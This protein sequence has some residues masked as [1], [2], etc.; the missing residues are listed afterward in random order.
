[1]GGLQKPLP[2]V[3]TAPVVPMALAPTATPI[4]NPEPFSTPASLSSNANGS[5]KTK[6]LKGT[7]QRYSDG[8]VVV[9]ATEALSAKR[10]DGLDG[11]LLASWSQVKKGDRIAVQQGNYSYLHRQLPNPTLFLNLNDIPADVPSGF[12]A[13]PARD[14]IASQFGKND[15]Q[16]EGTGARVMGL[17]QTNSEVFGASLKVSI[18]VDIFGSDWRNNE[19]RLRAMIDI[20]FA[21][22]KRMVRV[23]LVDIGPAEHVAAD[24]DLTWACDQFLGTEGQAGVRY[25]VLVPS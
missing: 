1:M 5:S 8:S 17:I 3:A 18:L 10:A 2:F 19:K 22:N 9:E 24:V 20:F 7:L 6:G 4:G 14:A 16:D 12:A 15:T 11:T 13:T 21:D 23:P 25:R